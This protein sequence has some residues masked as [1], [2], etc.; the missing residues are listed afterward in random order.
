M[1]TIKPG[2]TAFILAT[3]LTIITVVLF[4]F[5]AKSNVTT[6]WLVFVPAVISLFLI[7]YFIIRYYLQHFI[8]EKI[9]LIYKTIHSLKLSK[10]EKKDK[11]I[12][13]DNVFDE[14]GEEV[15]SWA[16]E[17]TAEINTLRKQEIYRREFLANVS[18]ELKTP[19]FNIQGF[20]LTLID[21]GLEDPEINL[22]YLKKIQNNTERMITI[23]EDLEVI[24]RLESGEAKPEMIRFDISNLVKDVFDFLD[25]K[26]R[27]KSIILHLSDEDTPAIYVKADKEKIRQVLVNIID[28]SIKYGRDYGRTKVSFYDMDENLLI[29]ISDNGFGIEDQHLPH[30]FERFYRVDKHRA[31]SVGGSGLGLAIVKHIIEAHSQTI[32]VRSAPG[33]GTTFSLTLKLDK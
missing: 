17:R 15:K 20:A 22:D 18:H 25:S 7:E 8:Y 6:I 28:N 2:N 10:E 13:N 30:L 5:V 23:V 1:R 12:Y 9:K 16:T 27:Q 14:V 24:S 32:N 33:V 11:L 31:R 29:E 3:I 19:L 26:A 21:G 4:M